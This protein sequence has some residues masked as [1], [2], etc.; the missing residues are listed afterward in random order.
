[1]K[2]LSIELKCPIVTI[3][4]R[5]SSFD[6]CFSDQQYHLTSSNSLN[7]ISSL[8]PVLF[9]PFNL[10]HKLEPILTTKC[11][12]KDLIYSFYFLLIDPSQWKYS[13]SQRYSTQS[14]Q[15]TFIDNYCSDFQS[16]LTIEPKSLLHGYYLSVFTLSTKSNLADFR[17][18]IQPIE[19][20]RSDL[21]TTFSGNQTITNDGDEVSLDFYSTTIDP[22]DNEFDRRKLNF[23]LLCYPENV[24]ILPDGLQLG[25]SRSTENNPQNINNW[26]I[27][28]SNL[29]LIFRQSELNIHF[30][31]KECFV[32]NRQLVQFDLDKKIININGHNLKFNSGSLYFLIIIRHLIDGRQLISR[33]EVNKQLNENLDTTDL[34]LLEEAMGNLDDLALS[35]PKRAVEVITNLADKLNEM[36]ENSVSK[37]FNC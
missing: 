35:N 21:I 2:F 22:D 16:T 14:F 28:W 29:N 6:T 11:S 8:S 32:P 7:N 9:L 13:R 20:I 31:E 19:I 18:F 24:H 34:N 26:S 33:L 23:T 36:S 15:E 17:Q 37:I 5:T 30:Y 3:V 27:Q 12:N 1:M 4:N 10:E 25:S